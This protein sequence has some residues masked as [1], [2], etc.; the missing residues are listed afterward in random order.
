MNDYDVK[1]I[2]NKVFLV[3][4][5]GKFPISRLVHLHKVNVGYAAELK[6]PDEVLVVKPL[7]AHKAPDPVQTPESTHI[8]VPAI[9]E[10]VVITGGPLLGRTGVVVGRTFSVKNLRGDCEVL[11]NTDGKGYWVAFSPDLVKATGDNPIFVLVPKPTPA[12]TA[13]PEPPVPDSDCLGGILVPALGQRIRI[14][15]GDFIGV[16]GF[17]QGIDSKLTP[18]GVRLIYAHVIL[19]MTG[20]KSS[21]HLPLSHVETIGDSPQYSL[22]RK[23]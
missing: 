21:R 10:P 18:E 19:N 2:D 16:E 5:D 3:F 8:S 6:D 13:A 23:A 1:L 22:I 15:A 17:F 9:G 4:E 11:V 12:P 20:G 14:T 7:R